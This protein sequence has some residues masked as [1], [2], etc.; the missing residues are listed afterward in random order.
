M[1]GLSYRLT[2]ILFALGVTVHNLEEAL[3]LVHWAR[4]HTKLWFKPNPL[5]YWVL[6]SLVSVVIWIVAISVNVWPDNRTFQFA[7]SGFALAMAFNA[8]FPHLAISIAKHSYSPGVGTGMLLNLPLGVLLVWELVSSGAISFSDLWTHSLNYA[9]A[10]GIGAFG[11]LFM[12]H[13]L[14][15]WFERERNEQKP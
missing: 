14:L 1:H 12:A 4:S 2:A 9:V 5:I 7:L 3:F 10:L 13:A 11:S 8:A 15:A 6:T